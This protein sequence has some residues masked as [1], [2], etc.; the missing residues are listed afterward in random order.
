MKEAINGYGGILLSYKAIIRGS[1]PHSETEVSDYLLRLPDIREYMGVFLL[2]DEE[3]EMAAEIKLEKQGDQVDHIEA[4]FVMDVDDSGATRLA[5]FCTALALHLAWSVQDE[6]SG[7]EISE[8]ELKSR[9]M[10][11]N[12]AQRKGCLAALMNLQ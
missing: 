10:G 2:R 8:M 6:Q 4:L 12:I 3:E 5:A 7:K 11:K 1:I 9:I